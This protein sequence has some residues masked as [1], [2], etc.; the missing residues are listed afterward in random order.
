MSVATTIFDNL[1]ALVDS[2]LSGYTELP[3]RITTEANP[4][5]MLTKGFAV[6]YGGEDNE[7][8]ILCNI[9]TLERSFSVILSNAIISTEHDTDRRKTLEKNIIEDAYTFIKALMNDITL[10]GVAIDASYESQSAIEYLVDKDD[11]DNFLVLSLEI[12]VK[13]QEQY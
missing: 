6:A 10:G 7:K 11:N 12:A 9:A 13:Y 8:R 3:D 2:S 5:R 1:I 4:D